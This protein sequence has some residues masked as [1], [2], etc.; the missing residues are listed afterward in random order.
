MSFSAMQT[1]EP[2]E[3]Q[4]KIERRERQNYQDLKRIYS[5]RYLC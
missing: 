2:N 3:E 4:R 5:L 1:E